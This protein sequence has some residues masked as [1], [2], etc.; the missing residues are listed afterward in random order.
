MELTLEEALKKITE[1]E[2]EIERL[3]K[4]L[5]DTNLALSIL[6]NKPQYNPEPLIVRG[7]TIKRGEV[8]IPSVIGNK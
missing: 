4:E 5:T 6:N 8:F 7:L 3:N 1:L 2:A